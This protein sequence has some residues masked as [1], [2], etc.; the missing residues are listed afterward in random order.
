MICDIRRHSDGVQF[1]C[2]IL[3]VLQNVSRREGGRENVSQQT[4]LEEDARRMR[5]K[6]SQVWKENDG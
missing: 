6:I 3:H 2:N 4:A 1:S 5:S